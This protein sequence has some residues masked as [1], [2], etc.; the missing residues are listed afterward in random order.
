MISLQAVAAAG[1][2]GAAAAVSNSQNS[3]G[4]VNPLNYLVFSG[5]LVAIGL[6][7]GILFYVVNPWWEERK[8][9]KYEQTISE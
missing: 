6:F 8:R 2:G 7:Y 9:R 5:I 3:E 4:M 1:G